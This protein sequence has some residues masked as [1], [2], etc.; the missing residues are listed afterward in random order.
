MA[1]WE[2]DSYLGGVSRRSHT[3]QLDLLR[4][5]QLIA[6]GACAL[7]ATVALVTLGVHTWQPHVAAALWTI[8]G[9]PLD[10][11]SA[12]TAADILGVTSPLPVAADD[13]VPFLCAMLLVGV[14][15]GVGSTIVVLGGAKVGGH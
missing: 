13:S 7:L 3:E 15:I 9:R 10:D 14:L 8:G 2:G 1:D 5:L 11:D 4:S 12:K 6:L